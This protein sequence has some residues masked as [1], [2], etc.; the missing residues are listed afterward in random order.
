[1]TKG[2]IF[3]LVFWAAVILFFAWPTPE[4]TEE[5]KVAAA[6]Q[7]EK[8][9]TEAT[10]RAEARAKDAEVKA[11]AEEIACIAKLDCIAPKSREEA[12]FQCVPRIEAF[13]KYDHE[14][15]T[16]LVTFD[17]WRWAG[18]PRVITFYGGNIKLQNGFGAWQPHTYECDFDINKKE[19]VDVRVRPGRL[20]GS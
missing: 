10:A 9:A 12:T 18:P 15:T 14:W 17:G 7:A 11:K 16:L 20:P 19:I 6:I 3:T 1:M 13:A 2:N 5:E 8:D 4:L